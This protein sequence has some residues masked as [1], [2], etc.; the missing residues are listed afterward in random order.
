MR[1]DC[2]L[3]VSNYN[4]APLYASDAKFANNDKDASNLLII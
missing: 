4:D 1:C 3:I 2:V